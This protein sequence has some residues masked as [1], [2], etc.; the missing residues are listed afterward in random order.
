MASGLNLLLGIT[1]FLAGTLSLVNAILTLL[2]ARRRKNRVIFIFSANWFLQ[3]IFWFLDGIAHLTY[4]PLIMA[5]SF[6]PHTI[7]VLC[8]FIYIELIEKENVSPVK[9]TILVVIILMYLFF[10]FVPLFVTSLIKE[11]SPFSS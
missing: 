1:T 5:I 2:Y 4:T 3:A 11:V 9:V 7:G 6:V 10:S 8:L